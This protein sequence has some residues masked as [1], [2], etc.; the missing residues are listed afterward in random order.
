MTVFSTQGVVRKNY[1]DSYCLGP[2][3]AACGRS[4]TKLKYWNEYPGTFRQDAR[5]SIRLNITICVVMGESAV[6]RRE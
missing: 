4:Q 2:S 5:H 3:N 6:S 1:G